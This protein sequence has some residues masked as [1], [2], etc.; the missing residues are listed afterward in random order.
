MANQKKNE[1]EK[2][3]STKAK[4]SKTTTKK[5][6]SKTKVE[7]KKQEAPKKSTVKKEKTSSKTTASKKKN[8]VILESVEYNEEYD[9]D[10]TQLIQVI[11]EEFLTE[12]TAEQ[13]EKDNEKGIV[14]L[15]LIIAFLFLVGLYYIYDNTKEQDANASGDVNVLNEEKLNEGA[16][17]AENANSEKKD[18]T[19]INYEHIQAISINQYKEKLDAN[20]KMIV[21]I[22]S[23]Y[24]GSCTVFEPVLDSVLEDLN[25]TA[26][27]IDVATFKT[28]EEYA[29]F[30]SLFDVSGT[31]TT[32][33]I[34]NKEQK[35]SSI[36]YRSKEATK[37]WLE[38]NY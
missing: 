33:I 16:N 24:C 3:K 4:T 38:E 10:K 1:E 26:Y 32:Y 23:K 11:D 13:H 14:I 36:G 31:P 17:S 9:N 19:T 20:E 7:A 37:T 12:K 5:T 6:N 27:K 35:A 28:E 25:Q 2:K 29:T 34:E 15:F 30:Q 21:L 8:P 22:A 18:S